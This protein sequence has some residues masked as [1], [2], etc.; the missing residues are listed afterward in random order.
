VDSFAYQ[1]ISFFSPFFFLLVDSS[2]ESTGASFVAAGLSAVLD[3]EGVA[4]CDASGAGDPVAP[5][6]G[7]GAGLASGVGVVVPVVLGAVTGA[8]V[9][10]AGV[11][12]VPGVLAS[13][14]VEP[15]GGAVVAGWE[16]GPV[17]IISTPT[18]CPSAP[19]PAAPVLASSGVTT[20]VPVS[21]FCVEPAAPPAIVKAGPC[22]P[23]RNTSVA[24]TTSFGGFSCGVPPCAAA[25][26]SGLPFTNV[27]GIFNAKA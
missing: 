4:G 12:V 2:L 14:D 5:G 21:A 20:S 22:A 7:T 17:L 19:A 16:S 9:S 24:E 8:L 13:G 3:D 10:A 25:E 11:T 18:D 26:K 1:G 6:V 23:G 27:N 15:G